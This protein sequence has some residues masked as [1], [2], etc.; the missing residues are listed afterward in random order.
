MVNNT[1]NSIAQIAYPLEIY[2]LPQ[3]SKSSFYFRW[4]DNIIKGLVAKINHPFAFC[5]L[6]VLM[7]LQAAVETLGV[8]RTFHD[9]GRADLA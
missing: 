3:N 4:Y 1:P 7:L 6:K 8:A 5:T 9:K 2:A